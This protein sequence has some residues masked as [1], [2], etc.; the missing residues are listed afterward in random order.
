MEKHAFN[1]Y[2]LSSRRKSCRDNSKKEQASPMFVL[3]RYSN[4][5]YDQTLWAPL[6]HLG[7]FI[8]FEASLSGLKRNTSLLHLGPMV[9]YI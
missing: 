7:T 4:N 8:T 1:K 3:E 5:I 9:F 2:E 6:L